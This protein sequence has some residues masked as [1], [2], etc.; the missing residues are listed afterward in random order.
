MAFTELNLAD[1]RKECLS[2]ESSVL[3]ALAETGVTLN[4]VIIADSAV[5]RSDIVDS[6]AS[7]KLRPLYLACHSLL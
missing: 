6:V 1:L 4:W 3:E 7:L 2:Q 5:V